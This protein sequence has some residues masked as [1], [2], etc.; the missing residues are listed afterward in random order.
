M[1]LGAAVNGLL[2]M[3][4]VRPVDGGEVARRV[5]SRLALEQKLGGLKVVAVAN[6]SKSED[7]A[8]ER[9]E[10]RELRTKAG[11]P[12]VTGPQQ[13]EEACAPPSQVGQ[14]DLASRGF[15]AAASSSPRRL[16]KSTDEAHARSVQ[17]ECPRSTHVLAHTCRALCFVPG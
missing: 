4:V 9:N 13:D 2:G 15:A 8:M 10:Q 7:S 16:C 14:S 1:Q 12:S 5:D 6:A 11:T 17:N 3:F